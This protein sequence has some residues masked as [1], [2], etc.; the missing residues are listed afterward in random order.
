MTMENESLAEHYQGMDE[1]AIAS[2]VAELA[3]K[4]GVK[5]ADIAAF[6]EE[7]LELARQN[8][9]HSELN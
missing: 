4:Y 9:D 6:T 5:Q 8:A 2:S 7:V 1:N 3:T